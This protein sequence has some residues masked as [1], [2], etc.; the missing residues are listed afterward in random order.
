ML[1]KSPQNKLVKSSFFQKN[2]QRIF[3]NIFKQNRKIII[4]NSYASFP[5]GLASLLAIML[6]F[7][8]HP[9]LEKIK[10][11]FAINNRE[12]NLSYLL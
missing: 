6:S 12:Y 7:G 10:T 9:I 11:I 8:E 3:L 4:E 5:L 1:K 2:W